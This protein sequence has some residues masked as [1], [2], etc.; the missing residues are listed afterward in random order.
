MPHLSRRALLVSATAA[1]GALTLGF[2]FPSGTALAG[3]GGDELTAWIVIQPDDTVIIRVARSEMGQGCF[4]ALPMLV[5]EELGC[6]WENVRPEYAPPHENL[7]RKRVWGDMS[8]A[9]SRS[10]S[11]S[12]EYLRRAG[13]TARQMLIAAAAARWQAPAA[14][15]HVSNSVVMHPPSGRSI[16]FGAIAASA[17]RM[18][19]PATVTLKQPK[20]WKLIGTPQKNFGARAK[21]VGQTIYGI[22]V[23]VPGM[24]LAA[25]AHCPVF[26]G[27]LKGVDPAS[28]LAMKGVRQVVTLTDAVA[29]VAE[30][31]WQ[32]QRA[33]EALQ[34][35][36]DLG[37]N[38]A[39]S[40]ADITRDLREGLQAVD[41]DVGREDGDVETALAAA[42]TR[43]EAD[44][45]VPL[46]AHAT[47]EPQ[48]CTA[49]VTPEKVE[50]WA[51]TQDGEASLATAAA[52]AG[53]PR[54]RVIVHKMMLGG[55]FGRRGVS[56]DFVHQAVVIAKA[57]QRPV[58]LIWSREEDI[59][60]DFYRP[61]AMARM[62]AGLDSQG[63]PS[64]WSVRVS[65]PSIMAS[66][67]G[68]A[69][70]GGFDRQ[71]VQG[72]TEEME[73]AIPN[74]RVEHAMHGMA[75]PVGMWR[76]VNYSQNEFFKECFVDEM[77]HAAGQDS[78]A[79]RRQLLISAPRP[80]AVLDA[81]ARA[82]G[83]GKPLPLRRAQ[84]I[85]LGAMGGT[86]CAQ[87]VEISVNADG[88]VRVHRVVSAIDCGHVVNP[89]T[90]VAQ[91]EG[92]V[93]FALAAALYGEVTIKD[94]RVEQSNFHDYE[95]LRLAET[96]QIETVIVPSAGRWGGAGEPPVA[97]LAPALCNAI[98]A[99]TRRRIRSLPIRKHDLRL[100]ETQSSRG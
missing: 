44:Y 48:N 18:P 37:D 1:G 66:L 97:P 6:D 26:G 16:G 39:L 53:M 60:H 65:S 76:A 14:E 30:S 22:D 42:A 54:N 84:G 47:M 61:A 77:A 7:A 96:P 81:A 25:I 74:Y 12:H 94:G 79:F 90:I 89:S 82:A 95:M 83:W 8:T 69:M 78:Y 92:A 38:A 4:T 56:Q 98:F 11:A 27:S 10:V 99:A 19:L 100:S 13:A 24:L 50:V 51:P 17:A 91:T 21:V 71:T 57:V 43:I 59:Q 64:A 55:G 40:S 80:R 58:K 23:T 15:C 45:A 28:A 33:V 31:W 5:A 73:Y 29:V 62:A 86:Y 9:A 2:G 52:A 88:R 35:L 20:D 70:V 75:V 72:L 41:A 87:V 68:G 36:W 46:L 34:P 32:A 85:A 63:M 67:A 3:R 93:L 49:H